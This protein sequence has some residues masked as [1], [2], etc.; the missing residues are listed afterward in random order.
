MKYSLSFSVLLIIFSH[1]MQAKERQV[2]PA[3]QKLICN[4]VETKKP[5]AFSLDCKLPETKYYCVY[6]DVYC[7]LKGG[8]PRSLGAKLDEEEN[9]AFGSYIQKVSDVHEYVLAGL[10]YDVFCKKINGKCP[11]VSEC[12][13]E[14]SSKYFDEISGE[15]A[16]VRNLKG[17]DEKG[18]RLRRVYEVK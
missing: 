5:F 10:T 6:K 13:E 4:E 17:T 11:S 8:D 12:M 14:E 18:A 15:K 3:S 2:Y 1:S 9:I 16:S 7:E